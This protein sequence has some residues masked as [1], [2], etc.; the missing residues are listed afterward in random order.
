MIEMSKFAAALDASTSVSEL[1]NNVVEARGY[2]YGDVV[3][4]VKQPATAGTY[5]LPTGMPYHIGFNKGSQTWPVYFLTG[6]YTIDGVTKT[7]LTFDVGYVTTLYDK[8]KVTVDVAADDPLLGNGTARTLS[9]GKILAELLGY[10]D[11]MVVYHSRNKPGMAVEFPGVN[12]NPTA[13][14]QPL[15]PPVFAPL[16]YVILELACATGDAV[17]RAPNLLSPWHAGQ[18]FT[19]VPPANTPLVCFQDRSDNNE[20]AWFVPLSQFD[21]D[22]ENMTDLAMFRVAAVRAALEAADTVL[23][24]AVAGLA[25]MDASVNAAISALAT[26]FE[27][28]NVF[29]T[30]VKQIVSNTLA[31]R[32]A[33]NY[34]PR[35]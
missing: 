11:Y 1:V 8:L 33:T 15:D 31:V 27:D 24:T 23:T 17:L 20:R 7:Y 6:K 10:D 34:I 13:G 19:W 2:T 29:G 12:W 21:T 28:T 5:A 35:P 30:S 22:L 4:S 14:E 3:A 16:Y 9:K 18:D 32:E 25:S 26:A